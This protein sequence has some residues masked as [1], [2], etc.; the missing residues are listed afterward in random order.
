M[1]GGEVF[2]TA[3]GWAILGLCLIMLSLLTLDRFIAWRKRKK[4][5]E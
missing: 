3:L 4:R 5:G 1:N 2:F